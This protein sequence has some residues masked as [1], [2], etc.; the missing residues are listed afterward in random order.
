MSDHKS[1]EQPCP[2]GIRWP[3]PCDACEEIQWPVYDIDVETGLYR[4]DVC[5]KLQAEHISGA[6]EFRDA[7][8]VVHDSE[9]FY[10]ESTVSEDGDR[11]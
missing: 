7:D 10:L 1:T 5:G 4:I 6:A 3:H 9:S 11:G 2:H 8:G